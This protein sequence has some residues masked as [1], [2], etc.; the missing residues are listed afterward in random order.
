MFN[1]FARLRDEIIA[2]T[3]NT[4]NPTFEGFCAESKSVAAYA[5][6]TDAELLFWSYALHQKTEYFPH[7]LFTPGVRDLSAFFGNIEYAESGPV[8][9][10]SPYSRHVGGYYEPSTDAYGLGHVTHY[11]A[12]FCSLYG[13]LPT[14]ALKRAVESLTGREGYSLEIVPRADGNLIVLKGQYGQR[15]LTIID[16]VRLPPGTAEA[17]AEDRARRERA[18]AE[19]ENMLRDRANLPGRVGERIREQLGA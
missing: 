13:S 16:E 3:Q 19:L 7:A 6:Y 14:E 11:K 12:N 18:D 9:I 2:Y 4:I 8:F 15:W 5:K 17:I 1:T 10:S